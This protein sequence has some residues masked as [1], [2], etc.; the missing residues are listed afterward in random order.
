MH[1]A[2]TEEQLLFRDAVRDLLANECTAADV[3]AGWEAPSGRIDGLWEQ[4]G[5]MGVLG[6]TAPASVG[7]LDMDEVTLVLLLEEAGRAA[8]PEPLLEH[9]AIG[10]PALAEAGEAVLLADA[11]SGATTLGAQLE[12]YG[13][14][15]GATHMVV[16][17]GDALALVEA[18]FADAKTSIDGS[19]RLTT[20]DPSAGRPLAGADPA[21]AFDR[22]AVGCA[23]LAVGVAQHLLDETVAYV[24]DRHQFGKPVGSYQAVKHHLAN[25]ALGI[26][27]ARPY[28][29]RAAWC[30]ATDHADRS[31]EVS[32]AKALASDAVDLACRLALQCHGAIGYTYEY[33]LQLWL[34]RGWTLAATYGDAAFHRDRVAKALHLGA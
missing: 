1:F 29:Y 4:F 19:R 23:A 15:A 31:R 18:P 28:T 27:F 20:A 22:G 2:F 9:V 10:V 3:R 25:V 24:S 30:V 8:C 32:A 26:E 17:D 12:A 7:G 5:A 11:V 6:V 13:S 21:K 14:P 34:K 33:D 16:A